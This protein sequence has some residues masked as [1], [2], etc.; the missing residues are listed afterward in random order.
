MIQK[1]LK[2]KPQQKR[3]KR[4]HKTETKS[5]ENEEAEFR[6]ESFPMKPQT[7]LTPLNPS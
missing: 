7:F 2:P 5:A 1:L 4:A 6:N 3:A